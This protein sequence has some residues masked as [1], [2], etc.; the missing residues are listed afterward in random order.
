[1]TPDELTALTHRPGPGRHLTTVEVDGRPVE[2]L[3]DSAPI[4]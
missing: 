1:M 3:A 4:A 2:S